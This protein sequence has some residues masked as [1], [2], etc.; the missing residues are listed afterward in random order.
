MA[1]VSVDST[2]KTVEPLAPAEI[3]VT[4]KPSTPVDLEIENK[5]SNSFLSAFVSKPGIVFSEKDPQEELILLL[6]AHV[7]TMVPWI[8]ITALM[9]LAPIVA[10][11]LVSFAG[12][13]GVFG[14]GRTAALTIFWYLGTFTYAFLNFLYWYFNVYIVT[15]ERVIDV[16]WYSVTQR[17]VSSTQIAKVQDVNASQGG[18]F[19]GMF[20]YG[21]IQIQT[22]GTEEN[23]E[24]T[25][26][27]HPQLVARK[28]E[29]LM[30]K[31]ERQWEGNDRSI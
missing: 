7:V 15:D 12:L 24:F 8:L 27:P 1:R 26:V 18:V 28:I 29:E 22:A 4:S 10:L 14:V 13:A 11:P 21:N 25:A 23:F 6:R 9:L 19:A 3:P 30:G 2:V 16:D 20:D 17:K 31:E 5:S